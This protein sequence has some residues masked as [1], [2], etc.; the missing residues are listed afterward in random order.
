MK[1]I[2]RQTNV[3]VT[4]VMRLFDNVNPTRKIED[5]SSE[6]ICIDKFKGNAGGAKYQCIIVDPVKKQIVEILRDRRQDVLI[7]YFKGLQGRDKVKY[8]I[9]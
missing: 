6:A 8:F 7:E 4:T 2:A 1:E 3:S 5:F 9:L